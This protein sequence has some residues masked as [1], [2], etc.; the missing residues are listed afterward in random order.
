MA[1]ITDSGFAAP[2]PAAR[3]GIFERII[4]FLSNVAEANSRVRAV[5]A[6]EAMSDA[7]LAALGIERSR[8]V[9][10]VFRDKMGQ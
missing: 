6:L 4:N 5:E 10:H 3:P 7:Q 2:Q 9:H 1:H 8:I